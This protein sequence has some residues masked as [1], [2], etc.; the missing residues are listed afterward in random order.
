MKNSHFSSNYDFTGRHL[1]AT[2]SLSLHER[3]AHQ[4]RQNIN[5]IENSDHEITITPAYTA[6]EQ[7]HQQHQAYQNNCNTSSGRQLDNDYQNHL[8][9]STTKAQRQLAELYDNKNH[10][11]NYKTLNSDNVDAESTD[12][13]N[14]YHVI[15]STSK[16]QQKGAYK[17]KRDSG[18]FNCIWFF[19]PVPEKL[20]N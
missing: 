9:I 14:E 12:T 20:E 15:K 19:L 16:Y 17:R 7:H 5:L 10:S 1:G 8:T 2:S 11:I 13:N 18:K 4:N 6:E 3:S